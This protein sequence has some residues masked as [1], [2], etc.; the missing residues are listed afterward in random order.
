MTPVKFIK[1]LKNKSKNINC[2][3]SNASK[4]TGLEL[5]LG[6]NEKSCKVSYYRQ[7]STNI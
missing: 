5:V 6:Y 1:Y 2:I 4:P 3:S 7:F